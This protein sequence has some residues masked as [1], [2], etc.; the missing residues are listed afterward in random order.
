MMSNKFHITIFSG[1]YVAYL[2][3]ISKQTSE[4]FINFFAP[5][6]L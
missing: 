4:G 2:L 6:A 3:L 1:I 5:R